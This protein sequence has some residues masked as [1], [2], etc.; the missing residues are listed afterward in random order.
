MPYSDPEAHREHQR[1]YQLK[2]Y[3]RWRAEARELLGGKCA[4]CGSGEDDLQFDHVDPA[5]KSFALGSYRPSRAEWDAEVAKCQLLCGDCH[6]KKT[7]SEQRDD[8]HGTWGM[9][10][11]RKCRCDTCRALVNA[12]MREY[13]RKRRAEARGKAQ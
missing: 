1:V 7:A 11:N 4:D 9:Y 12:Y 2:K 3:H 13:K 6:K 8:T 10:R 5:T